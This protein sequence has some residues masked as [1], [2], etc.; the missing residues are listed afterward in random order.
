MSSEICQGFLGDLPS[1]LCIE[2]R[3]VNCVQ[4]TEK[5]KRCI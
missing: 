5:N 3:D 1:I 4:V 2:N